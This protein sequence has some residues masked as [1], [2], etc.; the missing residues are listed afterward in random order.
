MLLFVLCVQSERKENKSERI[1]RYIN[2]INSLICRWRHSPNGTLNQLLHIICIRF[3]VRG[4]GNRLGVAAGTAR[5]GTITTIMIIV[6]VVVIIILDHISF[7]H[8]AEPLHAQL[9]I[10]IDLMRCRQRG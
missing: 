7:V 10:D 9:R 6:V 4:I 2:K 3:F 5:N 8:L 1:Y